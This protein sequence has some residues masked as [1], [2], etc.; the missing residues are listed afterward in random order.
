AGAA[1]APAFP[2]PSGFGRPAMSKNSGVFALREG[3]R[4]C[5]WVFESPSTASSI[6]TRWFKWRV[7]LSLILLRQNPRGEEAR[8]RRLEPWGPRCGLILRD[9]CFASSSE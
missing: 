3:D 4:L 6:G 8:M 7:V 1:A 2:A 5:V 9:A